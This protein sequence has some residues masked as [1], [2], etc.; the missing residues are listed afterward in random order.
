MV[1][2]SLAPR[3]RHHALGRVREESRSPRGPPLLPACGRA[4]LQPERASPVRIGHQ[5]SCREPAISCICRRTFTCGLE[6]TTRRWKGISRRPMSMSSTSPVNTQPASTPMVITGTISTFSGRP[7]RWRVA[8]VEAMKAACD[9]AATITLRKPANIA[10]K[11]LT[12]HANLSMIRFG[13]WEELLK[14]PAPPKGLGFMDG[15]GGWGVGLALI[16]TGRLPGAEGEQVLLPA[17]K[18]DPPGSH[19]GRKD[20]AGAS[21]DCGAD[22]V[23]RDRCPPPAL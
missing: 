11:N 13:R 4:S 14:E 5:A 12:S 3:Y 7:R 23:R 9:V 2:R 16:A 10:R 20:P 6:S 8:N 22:P 1:D 17:S 19:D 15:S 18:A 21:R